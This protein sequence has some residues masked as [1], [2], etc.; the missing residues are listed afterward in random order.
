MSETL[1]EITFESSTIETVDFAVY[2][3]LDEKMNVYATT[4]EGWKKVPVIWVSAERAHQIKSDK[5]NTDKDNTDEDIDSL[6]NQ[7]VTIA[8]L[9]K[10][11]EALGVGLSVHHIR[12]NRGTSNSYRITIKFENSILPPTFTSILPPTFTSILP[13]NTTK[14]FAR[15]V[16]DKNNNCGGVV[17]GLLYEV[18]LRISNQ[19][20][21]DFDI[22][23]EN[24][25][26]P[27]WHRH[28]L[29][30]FIYAKLLQ[31]KIERCSLEN[32]G[33]SLN[34]RFLCN[35]LTNVCS[36]IDREVISLNGF[37]SRIV[38]TGFGVFLTL[39]SS[40]ANGRIRNFQ[41]YIANGL[42]GNTIDHTW[43]YRTLLRPPFF[44]EANKDAITKII[45]KN[46]Q[47]MLQNISSAEFNVKK[48]FDDIVDDI[49]C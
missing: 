35:F 48:W 11:L 3:W 27:N 39:K 2:N 49:H 45:E 43:L 42:K 4:S 6:M 25:P 10:L 9:N 40:N 22:F 13:L 41:S 29:D 47:I 30:N 18:Y 7:P 46:K 38:S 5:D 21:V 12:T 14:A 8:K 16:I 33:T 37:I 31:R 36:D 34:D 26:Q 20:L 28:V 24:S 1:Q 15:N 17:F 32:L 44:N 23:I 19:L